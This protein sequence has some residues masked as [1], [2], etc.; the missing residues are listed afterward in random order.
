MLLMAQLVSLSQE[1]SSSINKNFYP[2]FRFGLRLSTITAYKIIQIF[3]KKYINILLLSQRA[4]F[5]CADFFAENVMCI[6]QQPLP[7]PVE[8]GCW[9]NVV[10]IL[11]FLYRVYPSSLNGHLSLSL[12]LYASK[13]Q[14]AFKG[15]WQGKKGCQ[16][17]LIIV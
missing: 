7:L 1:L 14:R 16:P 3:L 12:S 10:D 6:F 8:V 15:W 17:S 2:R 5:L 13:S 4:N 9:K 11:P